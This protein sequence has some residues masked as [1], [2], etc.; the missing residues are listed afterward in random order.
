M[1]RG[2]RGK[3]IVGDRGNEGIECVRGQRGLRR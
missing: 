2:W 3:V 1:V